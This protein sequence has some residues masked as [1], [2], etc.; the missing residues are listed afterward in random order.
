MAGDWNT[1]FFIIK[2]ET[3]LILENLS[4]FNHEEFEGG[5]RVQIWFVFS[6]PV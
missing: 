1:Y 2:N 5:F 3:L 6:L 4:E